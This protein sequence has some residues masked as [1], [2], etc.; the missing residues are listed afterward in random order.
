M[1]PE[2]YRQTK[3]SDVE[4][5]EQSRKDA[6]TVLDVQDFVSGCIRNGLKIE[7]VIRS[8]RCEWIIQELR[9]TNV[10]Q[11]ELARR[12]GV[13]RNTVRRHIDRYGIVVKRRR[14]ISD[15]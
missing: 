6:I 10:N 12:S 7:D 8:I 5:L 14:M 15:S 2:P 11:S 4:E 9:N 1:I 13:H 3:G